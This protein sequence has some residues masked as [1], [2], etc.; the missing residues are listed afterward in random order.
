MTTVANLRIL[1]AEDSDP[2]RAFLADNLTADGAG[3][4]AVRSSTLAIRALKT[5][6]YDIIVADLNGDTLELVDR[7]AKNTPIVVLIGVHDEQAR[8]RLLDRGADDVLLKPFSYP[9]LCSRIRAVLRRQE[10]RQPRVM[11]VGDLHID[12]AGRQVFVHGNRVELSQ[13]SFDLL[14]ALATDPTRVFTKA[15]L[16]ETVWKNAY[17]PAAT[18]TVD[19]H[20]GRLRHALTAAGLPRTPVNVWGVGYRLC[21]A[22]ASLEMAA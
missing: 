6:T 9:E 11:H 7:V 20:V 17:K 2:A 12:L 1:I 13:K 5:D 22:P 8:V 10:Q 19:S 16:I 15:E 18:R 4:E 14:R 21:D 3:I